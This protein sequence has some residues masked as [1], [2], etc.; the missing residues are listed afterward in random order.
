MSTLLWLLLAVKFSYSHS[1]IVVNFSVSILFVFFDI[2]IHDIVY[3]A[4]KNESLLP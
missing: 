2:Q 4:I 3:I 1:V